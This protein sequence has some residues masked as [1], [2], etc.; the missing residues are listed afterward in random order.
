MLLP[1]VCTPSSSNPNDTFKGQY[2]ITIRGGEQSRK[3]PF[4]EHFLRKIRKK[5][6]T[7]PAKHNPHTNKQGALITFGSEKG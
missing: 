5:T 2:L 3:V 4:R 7:N 6:T 1:E